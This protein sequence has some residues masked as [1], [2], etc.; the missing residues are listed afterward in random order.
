MLKYRAF[1]VLLYC[2][3]VGRCVPYCRASFV[4]VFLIRG[5]TEVLNIGCKKIVGGDEGLV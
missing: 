3:S 2:S 4:Y 1:F 5:E